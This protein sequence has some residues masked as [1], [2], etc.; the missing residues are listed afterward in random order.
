MNTTAHQYKQAKKSVNVQSIDYTRLPP[1]HD[2][3]FLTP[4]QHL[5]RTYPQKKVKY[6]FNN[7]LSSTTQLSTQSTPEEEKE[8]KEIEEEKNKEL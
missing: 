8:E 2:L 5:T 4:E 7:P 3:S 1:D 6:V